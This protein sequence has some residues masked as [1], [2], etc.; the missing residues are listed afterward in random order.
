M[1]YKFEKL[2]KESLSKLYSEFGYRAREI[3]NIIGVSED[4][5]LKRLTKYKIPTNP[6]NKVRV[7]ISIVFTGKRK[8]K[9]NEL[10]DEEL[11]R[12][13]KKGLTDAAIGDIYNMTG[14]GIAFRRGKL[15]I[16]VSMKYNE[17]QE[18]INKLK[19]TPK[20]I[21]SKDY[22]SL[23]KEGFSD[24]YGISTTIWRPHLKSL[25]VKSKEDNR[26]DSYPPLI[27]RQRVVIIGSMLGD[28]GIDDCP[29]FFEYHSMK[30]Q[31]YLDKKMDIL[32]PY[33]TPKKLSDDGKGM[34]FDTVAHRNF[35]EFRENFYREGVKGKFMPLELIKSDWD[36][37]ILATWFFDDGYYDDDTNTFSFAN[38][39]PDKAQ[40]DA[41]LNFLDSIY[42]W[43]FK[44][45]EFDIYRIIFSKEYYADF[46]KLLLKY[47]TPDMYYKI[48][49]RYLNHE[50]VSKVTY[51]LDSSIKPKFYRTIEDD[52]VKYMMEK[53]VFEML[54][55][56]GF[57][58]TKFTKDRLDYVLS[59]YKE[60][61]VKEK[62][63]IIAYNNTGLNLCEYFF[64]NIYDCYRKGYRAPTELWKDD[65]FL[66]ELTKNRLK[67]ANRLT[68]SS[69]RT[70]LKLC[71]ATVT[72]FKPSVA[73]FIYKKY[74]N[75]GKVYDYSCGFG[76]RMLAA[77]VLGLEYTGCEPNIKSYDN[78]NRFGSFLK[79]RTTGSFNI[80]SSGSEDF[81]GKENYFSL[82]FSSPP[83]FD[84][85]KYSDDS[86][87]SIIKYPK[88]EDWLINYWRN[89]VKNCSK[90]LTN[91]GFFGFCISRHSHE[92]L[93]KSSIQFCEELGLYFH[94]YYLV[95]FKHIF[96]VNKKYEVVLIFSKDPGMKKEI[97]LD[98][99]F[100]KTDFSEEVSEGLIEEE[101]KVQNNIYGHIDYVS[102]EEK[103]K[104]IYSE[105]GI[106]RNNYKDG[107]LL[108]YPAYVI[109]HHYNGWNAFLLA[110]G[111][112]PQYEAKTPLEKV[113]D[114]LNECQSRGKLL[115]FYDYEKETGK[116]ATRLKRLFNSGKSYSYLFEE[117]KSV[118]LK[119]ECWDEFLKKF[120]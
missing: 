10:T 89:T 81:L 61:V 32:S 62:D 76:S 119:P 36:D 82:A 85:E 113:K 28:G 50:M 84:Y 25:E 58:Y 79:D 41:F 66:M 109:E 33:S 30:Q 54:R 17:T 80:S 8:D 93:I 88:Y 116:P 42:G 48:P 120:D 103:M 53:R 98:K 44:A 57:P 35:S 110:C 46:V 87:Q 69:I 49:E 4:A 31:K 102:I 60:M 43:G 70:G 18:S 52:S 40:L 72:N 19:S 117:L 112:E 74:C 107:V 91:D 64:P 95:P 15:G 100:F 47:I 59:S 2:Y 75:N 92:E 71:K 111:I 96:S 23:T 106:S 45:D 13:C 16:T 37:E 6:R 22:Y 11:T 38:K 1:E 86:G 20:D 51:E 115:S 9:K 56:Y 63:H 5:I 21:L 65:S 90:M 29:R 7:D 78:L 27:K 55:K 99:I 104:N 105:E 67:Y 83:Y 68:D 24:K 97:P 101:K 73:S 3:G 108:G 118:A 12:L 94:D 34:R 77:M 26:L 114:Y 14:E 39:C